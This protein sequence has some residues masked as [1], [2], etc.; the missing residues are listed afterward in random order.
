MIIFPKNIAS[1]N[2]WWSSIFTHTHIYIY[3]YRYLLQLSAS[4]SAALASCFSRGYTQA[5]ILADHMTNPKEGPGLF[6][7]REAWCGYYE[8]M[9][10]KLH[11]FWKRWLEGNPEYIPVFARH[12]LNDC[13]KNSWNLISTDRKGTSFVGCFLESCKVERFLHLWILKR[14]ICKVIIR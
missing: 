10:W 5:E 6:F 11:G 3:I 2:D 12:G 9:Q 8:K 7:L 14:K 13:F 1:I 4:S